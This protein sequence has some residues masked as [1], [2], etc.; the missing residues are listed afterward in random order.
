MARP[1]HSHNWASR[2][3][4]SLNEIDS[5]ARNSFA[6]LP[7]KFR[8][9][10]KDLVIRVTDFPDDQMMDDMGLESPFEL[11]G[12]FEGQG[13]S[14]RFSLNTGNETNRITLF[15]RPILDYWSENDEALGD[16][17]THVLIQEIGRNFGLSD[18]TLD[19]IEEAV[20]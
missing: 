7:S 20:E 11:L 13:I 18:D 17:V 16:I 1:D 4:P 10:C 5:I 9:L 15:R 12:L 14:E 2:L 3:S 8:V 19:E 6:N